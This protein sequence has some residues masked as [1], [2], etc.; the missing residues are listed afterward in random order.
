MEVA[1]GEA[2]SLPVAQSFV[3]AG[4]EPVE[5]VELAIE[6]RMQSLVRGDILELLSV[7]GCPYAPILAWCERS[8]NPL[9]GMLVYGDHVRFWIKHG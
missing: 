1:P 6:R 5:I 7:A 3:D 2:A 9:V 8:G 4:G